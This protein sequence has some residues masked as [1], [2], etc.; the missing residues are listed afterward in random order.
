MI[1]LDGEIMVNSW[2]AAMTQY[3]VHCKTVHSI[4]ISSLLHCMQYFSPSSIT[5]VVVL[6]VNLLNMRITCYQSN[7]QKNTLVTNLAMNE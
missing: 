3:T 5:D 4:T 6:K 2:V 1:I 7:K